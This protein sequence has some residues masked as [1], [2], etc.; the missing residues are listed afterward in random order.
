MSIRRTNTKPALHPAIEVGIVGTLRKGVFAHQI[1]S[2]IS[3]DDAGY[4][5]EDATAHC[6]GRRIRR[7]SYG[8]A[9]K[10]G[11]RLCGNCFGGAS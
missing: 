11:A 9:A 5:I 7:Y 6:N 1:K 3:R 8:F 10:H 2:D 4:Q